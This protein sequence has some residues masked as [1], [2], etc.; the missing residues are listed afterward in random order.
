MRMRF[1][2][3]LLVWCEQAETKLNCCLVSSPVPNA[4][5]VK[6]MSI[7]RYLKPINRLRDPRGSLFASLPSEAIAAANREVAASHTSLY[8]W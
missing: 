8:T 1:A 3:I 6:K 5:L 4:V 2:I 7:R